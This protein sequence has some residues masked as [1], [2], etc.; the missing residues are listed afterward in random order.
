V[1]ALHA[2]D[3][4]LNTELGEVNGYIEFND[5]K[6]IFRIYWTG[7][8]VWFDEMKTYTRYGKIDLLIPNVGAVGADGNIGRRGLNAKETIQI[9]KAL[10]PNSIIPVHHST[11]SHYVEP[12]EALKELARKDKLHKR[13]IVLKENAITQLY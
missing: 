2:G 1:K 12:I 6:K 7:D 4:S 5:G 10:T 9:I 3:R 8:T 11:F 13:M